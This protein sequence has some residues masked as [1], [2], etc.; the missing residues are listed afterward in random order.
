[1]HAQAYTLIHKH[2]LAGIFD[3][4]FEAFLVLMT[5]EDWFG[6][7]NTPHIVMIIVTVTFALDVMPF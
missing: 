2:I 7:S 5:A 1:M 6:K 3:S 4:L